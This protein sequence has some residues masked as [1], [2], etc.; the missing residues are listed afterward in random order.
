MSI[1]FSELRFSLLAWAVCSILYVLYFTRAY[2]IEDEGLTSAFLTTLKTE[3]S[4]WFTILIWR[5][6]KQRTPRIFTCGFINLKYC[7]YIK[8]TDKSGL[9]HISF[10]LCSCSS[11]TKR[12]AKIIWRAETQRTPSIFWREDNKIK[13]HFHTCSMYC[14][15]IF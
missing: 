7:T 6:E 3:C 9:H 8:T 10:I 2:H 11:C 5:V 12:N 13:N 14:N 1:G 15:V 4:P